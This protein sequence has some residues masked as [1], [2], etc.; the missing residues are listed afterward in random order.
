MMAHHLLKRYES[1]YLRRDF[2]QLAVGR[3]SHPPYRRPCRE[4]T[5]GNGMS[6]KEPRTITCAQISDGLILSNPGPSNLCARESISKCVI[7]NVEVPR[8]R[9]TSTSFQNP[10]A[11]SM[12]PPKPPSL[13]YSA[14]RA[15]AN[16][17][18]PKVL[19]AFL[20]PVPL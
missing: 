20:D 3:Y 7:M 18:S 15:S 8:A 6:L 11:S 9:S 13:T 19:A 17:T 2:V 12:A 4:A 14:I 1:M 16:P 5:L 10:I